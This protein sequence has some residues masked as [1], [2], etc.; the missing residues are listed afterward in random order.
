[1]CSV[2]GRRADERGRRRRLAPDAPDV[3]MPQPAVPAPVP[4]RR[5]RPPR[6]LVAACALVASSAAAVGTLSLSGPGRAAGAAE[7]V[8]PPEPPLA[9]VSPTPVAH[10][11]G[12]LPRT[13]PLDARRWRAIVIHESG[14]PAG[15]M[16]SIER[17][18]WEAG[19]AGLGYHF[20]VGNGQGMEDGLVGIGYRWDRQLPGAHAPAAW[21][22]SARD[23]TLD[24]TGLNEAAIAICVIGNI[25]RRPLSDRQRRETQRLVRAL[26]VECAIPDSAVHFARDLV[27]AAGGRPAQG[28]SNR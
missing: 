9:A 2:G 17:R 26:Q 5:V 8:T 15:D 25:D 13:A 27:R 14:T 4:T 3:T 7:W 28:P 11:A 21:R 18:H 16:A 23:G 6:A 22:A 20:V 19:R 10:G 12:V 24:G 1:M